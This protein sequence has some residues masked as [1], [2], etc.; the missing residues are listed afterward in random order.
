MIHFKHNNETQHTSM[1]WLNQIVNVDAGSG[2]STT[3]LIGWGCQKIHSENSSQNNYVQVVKAV[4][5]T[6]E[7]FTETTSLKV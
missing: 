4:V 6:Q 1:A 3:P 5:V 2:E 7:C